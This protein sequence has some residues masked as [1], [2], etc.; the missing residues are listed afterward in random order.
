MPPFDL[1]FMAGIVI[2]VDAAKCLR[3]FGEDVSR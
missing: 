2:V 1:P 3:Q